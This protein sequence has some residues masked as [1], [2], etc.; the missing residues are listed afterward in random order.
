MEKYIK[1]AIEE[2]QRKII[3]N[4]NNLDFTIEQ[5]LRAIDLIADLTE[6]KLKYVR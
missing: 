6:L 2:A 1:I 4:S 3:V 5:H